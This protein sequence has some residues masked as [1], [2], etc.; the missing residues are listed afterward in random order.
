MM[1][2]KVH[3]GPLLLKKNVV[4]YVRRDQKDMG[5]SAYSTRADKDRDR[6]ME[7][8]QE[9]NIFNGSRRKGYLYL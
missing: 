5:I 9:H 6:Q 1:S 3:R 7:P 4:F 2:K 8:A